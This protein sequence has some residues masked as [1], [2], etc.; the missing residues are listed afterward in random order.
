MTVR[1]LGQLIHLEPQ[2]RVSKVVAD[3]DDLL[4]QSRYHKVASS[5]LSWLLAHLRIF[6]LFMKG[7]FDAYVL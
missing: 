1:Y 2:S 3:H 6:R 7:K 5:K 4:T